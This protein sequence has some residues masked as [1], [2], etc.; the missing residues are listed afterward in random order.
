MIILL[1]RLSSNIYGLGYF[2]INFLNTSLNEYLGINPIVLNIP[3]TNQILQSN[4][5]VILSRIVVMGDL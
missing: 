1:N 3:H 4:I 2:T 5:H